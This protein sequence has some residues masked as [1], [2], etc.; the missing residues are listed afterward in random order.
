YGLFGRATFDD[1]YR[2]FLVRDIQGE[3]VLRAVNPVNLVRL[4]SPYF[5]RIDLAA[6]LYDETVFRGQTF[7]ALAA[8]PRPFVM[9]HATSMANGGRFQ[10]TQDDFDLLRSDLGPFP[11]GRAAAASS[12]FPFLLSPVTVESFPAPPGFTLPAEVRNGLRSR[13]RNWEWYT[14]ASDRVAFVNA[15]PAGADPPPRKWL[16]LLDGGLSDNLGLRSILDAYD[17]STGFIG[18]RVNAG[19]IKRLVVI[20]VNA[21]TDPP[22]QLS[23]QERAPGL[24]EVFM[25][26]ATVS[27]ES[28][29]FDTLDKAVAR[30]TEREQAQS[31]IR[32][33]N[34]GLA[35][36]GAP[37]LPTFAQAVRTCFIEIDFGALPPPEREEFLSLPTTF[38]LPEDSVRKLIEVAGRLLNGS[39]DFQKLL[40]ALRGEATLGAGVGDTGNCS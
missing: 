1:F 31:A 18:Q 13:E 10:F 35:A 38:A 27:M 36:C 5:D 25:K 21:R 11:V 3:L 26:T 19:Q 15:P 24:G 22:E 37:P 29:S 33:C 23:R 12:A 20:A 39:A 34:Q 17:R 32:A 6:E 2:V 40:R 9:L 16:H 4:A 14:W 7:A 28:L 30:G 8:R